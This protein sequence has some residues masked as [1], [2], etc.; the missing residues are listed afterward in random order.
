MTSLP[1]DSAPGVGGSPPPECLLLDLETRQAGEVLK[2]GAGFGD[3]EFVRAGRFYRTAALRDL[4]RFA[5]GAECI[6][7]HNLLLH[8]RAVLEKL[9]PALALL[10]LPVIDTLW[11]SPICFPENPYH[12]LVKD[13]KLVSESLNDPVADE[14]GRTACRERV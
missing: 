12:R 14:I 4:D 7:G 6:V 1:E 11:L 3:R 13:Y 2:I 10:R 8:V 9:D 5:I